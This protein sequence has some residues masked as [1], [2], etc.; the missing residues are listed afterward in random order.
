MD[1][2]DDSELPADEGRAE[3]AATPGEPDAAAGEPH[4]TRVVVWDAPA[5]VERGKRFAVRIGVACASKC[6]LAGWRVE[7]RDH[8]GGRRATATLDGE[9]WPGTDALYAAEVTLAAP[10]TVGFHTWEATALGSVGAA[11]VG[12]AAPF[13][14]AVPVGTAAP[15]RAEAPRGSEAPAD[16]AATGDVAAAVD[17]AIPHAPGRALFGVRVVPAPGCLLTVVATRAEGGYA[18]E[19]ARV[20]AHPY[21]A[22]TDE[23][24]VA[25][26]RVPPGAYRLFVSGKGCIPFRFDGEVT[27]DTTIRA[28][29]TQDREL[30]DADIW[31]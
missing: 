3:A 1:S 10:E 14:A 19:G 6:A 29:L 8:T 15:V 7:V 18:V 25:E 28:E 16:P 13:G 9:R 4:A 20:V 30:S 11:P 5:A 27:A 24:G 31:S 23:R 17:P 22:V 21:R 26:M 2:Q 12:A